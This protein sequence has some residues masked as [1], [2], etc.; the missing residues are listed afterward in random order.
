M[1]KNVIFVLS[2]VDFENKRLRMLVF[3]PSHK[4]RNGLR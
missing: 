3:I 2:Y 1:S 4:S